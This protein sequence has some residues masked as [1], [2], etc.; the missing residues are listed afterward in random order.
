MDLEMENALEAAITSD[1]P[2]GEVAPMLRRFKAQGVPR[3]PRIRNASVHESSGAA[4][5]GPHSGFDSSA[6]RQ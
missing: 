1:L 5:S 3:P 6:A 4:H 2:P